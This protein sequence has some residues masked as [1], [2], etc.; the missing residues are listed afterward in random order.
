VRDAGGGDV[1]RTVLVAQNGVD[2]VVDCRE[3]SW[4]EV[5]ADEGSGF[6][7]DILLVERQLVLAE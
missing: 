5:N 6:T 3:R 2:R 1:L 4:P 7:V